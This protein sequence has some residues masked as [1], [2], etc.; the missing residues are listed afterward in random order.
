MFLFVFHPDIFLEN[1]IWMR[2][3]KSELLLVFIGISGY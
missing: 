1:I 2:E 3:K